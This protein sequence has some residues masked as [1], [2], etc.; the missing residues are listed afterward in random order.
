MIGSHLR[1]L[2]ATAARKARW[3]V[4]GFR[5]SRCRLLLGFLN[6]YLNVRHTRTSFKS[7]DANR[8]V[9]AHGA[10]SELIPHSDG[11]AHTGRPLSA[12]SLYIL[13]IRPWSMDPALEGGVIC[14]FY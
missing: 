12:K 3:E 11:F 2:G 5:L 4:F 14:G 7:N 1:K 13:G 8:D 10:S 9:A 6:H